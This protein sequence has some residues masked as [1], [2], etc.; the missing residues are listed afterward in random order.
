MIKN[1]LPLSMTKN[2]KIINVGQTVILLPF[3]FPPKKRRKD[4]KEKKEETW[5]Y[6]MSERYLY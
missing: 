3:L 5:F 4:E 1:I 2:F 6:Y